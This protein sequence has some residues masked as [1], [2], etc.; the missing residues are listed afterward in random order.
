MDAREGGDYYAVCLAMLYA[1]RR[2]MR[3]REKCSELPR[4]APY[5]GPSLRRIHNMETAVAETEAPGRTDIPNAANQAALCAAGAEAKS[6]RWYPTDKQIETIAQICHE[7]NR[8]VCAA[9]GDLS[10]LQEPWPDSPE[11]QKASIRNGVRF[12]ID[13]K[14]ADARDSHDR[15]METKLRDGWRYGPVK[16][17]TKKEHPNL[18][19]YNSLPPG[20]KLKDDLF[21]A[22]V[23]GY[24]RGLQR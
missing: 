3:P 23:H 17:A 6:V 22:I 2:Y 11:W 7:A 24:V 10:F 1:L 12:H 19:P 9:N 14:H 15:W 13:N 4:C 5:K 21:R 20:E 16:D 18:L 8:V